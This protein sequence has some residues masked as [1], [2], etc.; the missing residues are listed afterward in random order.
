[1]AAS[2]GSF[3]SQGSVMRL[4]W[5]P[6]LVS[7]IALVWML[8][9]C[10]LP[11]SS[12]KP[13]STC[14]SSLPGLRTAS[15]IMSLR[16]VMPMMS[17][18]LMLS[19]PSILDSS[20]FTMESPTPLESE[21]EP[22]DLQMASN[23]SKMMMC[24]MLLEP[25]VACSSSA[26]LNKSRIFCSEPPTNLSRISGPL[27]ILGSRA[28]NTCP[29]CLAIRVFPHPGGPNRSMPR[30]WWIPS[31]STMWSGK[32]RLANARLKIWLNSLSSPP[33]PI[34]PKSNVLLKMFLLAFM[35]SCWPPTSLTLA[36]PALSKHKQLEPGVNCPLEFQDVWANDAAE[37]EVAPPTRSRSAN[38]MLTTVRVSVFF[39]LERSFCPTAST[40]FLKVFAN[41]FSSFAASS[42]KNAASAA[43]ACWRTSTETVSV[44]MAAVTG[45]RNGRQVTSFSKATNTS[46]RCEPFRATLPCGTLLSPVV[47]NTHDP[48]LHPS[49]AN[50]TRTWV[51]SAP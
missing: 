16:L 35:P 24:S 15:S 18:L 12:G 13:I 34:C 7:R 8:R 38:S 9:I 26:S 44:W 20:W 30:T 43:A 2:S 10:S 28:F 46:S 3:C 29:I 33:I 42:S 32:M 22:R 21:L 47:E 14:T 50:S 4:G 37:A 45:T 11:A 17:T 27:T 49:H 36:P 48:R 19:T 6:L 40:W 23:S 39:C 31:C 5:R 51:S 1:M 25:S 41:S